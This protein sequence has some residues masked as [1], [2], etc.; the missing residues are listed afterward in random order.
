[1]L[2]TEPI[3]TAETGLEEAL[4]RL[5]RLVEQSDVEGARAFVR[6][7]ETAWP[8]DERVRYWARVLAPPRVVRTGPATG[9]PRKQEFAWLREHAAEYPGCWIALEGDRLLTADPD[10]KK[11]RAVVRQSGVRDA[12]LH[13]QPDLRE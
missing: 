5:K 3:L 8:E 13:F 1:M 4:A 10:L 6:E 7:V 11:V 2:E 12:L 9:R